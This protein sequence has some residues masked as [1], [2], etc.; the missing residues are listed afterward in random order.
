MDITDERKELLS[1]DGNES[2][3]ISKTATLP[4]RISYALKSQEYGK[5]FLTDFL[6]R[7]MIY[8]ISY[9][10]A[11]L[12][13][14]FLLFSPDILAQGYSI[15]ADRIV[16]RGEEQWKEW[17]SPRGVL[18]SGE[19]GSIQPIYVRKNINACLNA[20]DFTYGIRNEIRGGIS[21]AGSN[22]DDAESVV[23][24][25]PATYWEPDTDDPVRD[26]WIRVD[27]GRLVWMKKIV[28]R[29]AE[30]RHSDPF[31][32]FKIRTSAWDQMQQKMD[33]RI[34]GYVTDA[35]PSQ[36]VFEFEPGEP[37]C[38]YTA[39][40]SV[41]LRVTDTRG[42][43]AEEI[44]KKEYE[45]LDPDLRGTVMHYRITPTGEEEWLDRGGY[46][47]L[48]MKEKGPVRY[49]RREAAHLAEMEIWCEGENVC[50]G[51]LGRGGSAYASTLVDGLF[52]SFAATPRSQSETEAGMQ[53]D[54][55]SF[56]WI[57]A[58]R[59][60]FARTGVI[61]H[62]AHV[63]TCYTTPSFSV[64][65]SDGLKA[66]DGSL[67]WESVVVGE[68][69]R[70][71]KY[72][73]CGTMYFDRPYKM[74]HV[75]LGGSWTWDR[76]YEVQLFGQG[77]VPAVEMVSPLIETGE[78]RN[79]TSLRWDAGM[80]SGTEVEI[81][82]RTGDTLLEETRYFDDGGREISG[83][84]YHKL[85]FFK[86]GEVV[87]GLIPDEDWSTW[88][89]PYAYPEDR[90]SS[91]SP[92]TYLQI[93]ARLRSEDP[94]VCPT[95]RSLEVLF[96]SPLVQEIVGE[97][98][99]K[100]AQRE[101]QSQEFSLYLRPSFTPANMG[102]D[103]VVLYSPSH[104]DIDLRSLHTGRE[105]DFRTGVQTVFPVEDLHTRATRSD[106]VW[107][108]L[109]CPIRPP[110]ELLLRIDF[111]ATIYLTGTVFEAMVIHS[112]AP[113][114]AQHV[115]EGDATKIVRS[116]EMTVFVPVEN[117]LIGDVQISPGPFTP[118]GDGTNDKVRI[119]FSV[120]KMYVPVPVWVEILDLSGKSIRR[121]EHQRQ[122]SSGRYSIE[123][124]GR[125]REGQIVDPGVYVVMI[126]VGDRTSEEAED[127][128][129][130]RTVSVAY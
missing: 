127:R 64:L 108:C 44:S 13:W 18:S 49:Y 84:E 17:L 96:F 93:Q 66:M 55:G 19:D 43:K 15:E 80:P 110:E 79:L 38:A 24:G 114:V 62:A 105:G 5:C 109:P 47:K 28:V 104:V 78:L 126:G 98:H 34:L 122:I 40:Q 124:D 111:S 32:G 63:P 46:E 121:V 81:R 35:D 106:S 4:K 129:V 87:T 130:V 116:E 97:V 68:Y 42:D 90:I 100:A 112:S 113:D 22:L 12:G 33:W 115:D 11:F 26:G 76:V 9:I 67:I 128:V 54:L 82:T 29:F 119:D 99:P 36:R 7:K 21:D 8:M 72:A 95:L 23:D 125:D 31:L 85:P 2:H 101:G 59:I 65:R 86:Q 27:L 53:I 71:G 73:E 88:S 57:D 77:Y 37:S 70:T 118:N 92:R 103:E 30:G 3:L 89:F 45:E 51:A 107:I 61:G 58:A 91:P 41:E 117:R 1:A 102:F 20:Q 14:G 50:L 16:V 83:H 6:T 123:W 25:D 69:G 60:V 120:F 56:F 48:S 39:I 52:Q 94:E 10:Y 75:K 74:W